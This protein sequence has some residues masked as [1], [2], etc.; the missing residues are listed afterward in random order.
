MLSSALQCECKTHTGEGALG[1]KGGKEWEVGRSR[2][3]T[4]WFE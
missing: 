4:L 2:K 1:K 3:E